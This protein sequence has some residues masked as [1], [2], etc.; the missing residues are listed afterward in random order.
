MITASAPT[1]RPGPARPYS[2]RLRRP[3]NLSHTAGLFSR[4]CSTVTPHPDQ[5]L[6]DQLKAGDEQAFQG[7]IGRYHQKFLI[8]ARSIAG[9]VFAE[10]VVQDAWT[11]IYKAISRFEG[12]SSLSTWMIQIVSNEARSRLRREKRHSSFGDIEDIPA[13]GNMGSFDEAGHWLDRPSRWDIS[14]PELMLQED[15][16]RECIEH[17]LTTL[18]DGQRAVFLLRDVEQTPLAEIAAVL[19]IGESNVRVTLHR[20]RLKLM[21]VINHYQETGEC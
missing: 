1:F 13:A 4:E 19:D 16:L 3:G 14:T 9:D 15:Q 10:D 2:A 18:P 20:A 6:V 5:A 12:R 17:T 8:I 7:L 21:E 11:S